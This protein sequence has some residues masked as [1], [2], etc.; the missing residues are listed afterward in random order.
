MNISLK[1]KIQHGW[2]RHDAAV[3]KYITQPLK[4]GLKN[5]SENTANSIVKAGIP[6]SELNKTVQFVNDGQRRLAITVASSL[7][8]NNLHQAP[9]INL[10]QLIHPSA[11]AAEITEIQKH[12]DSI[13][14]IHFNSNLEKTSQ[15]SNYGN[16]TETQLPYT[17][18]H[19]LSFE[20]IL[21]LYE[22]RNGNGKKL[23]VPELGSTFVS[24]AKDSINNLISEAN[25]YY[26]PKLGTDKKISVP[27]EINLIVETKQKETS[28]R[29]FNLRL[30]LN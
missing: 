30:R 2:S 16:W 7:L 24:I 10:N 29:L 17:N 19:P 28:P 5:V 18:R 8:I 20:N 25:P 13:I 9:E 23:K 15:N 22:I 4:E 14:N 12:R 6:P 3:D 26:E 27:N 1:D 11:K 21:E